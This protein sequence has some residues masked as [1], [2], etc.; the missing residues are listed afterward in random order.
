MGVWVFVLR[1]V[2]IVLALSSAHGR[3]SGQYGNERISETFLH[4]D[5]H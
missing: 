4:A 3:L 2:E 1:P 5:P